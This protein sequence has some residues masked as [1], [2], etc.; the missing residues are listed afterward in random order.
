MS[1]YVKLH[2]VHQVPLLN[3]CSYKATAVWASIHLVIDR[4]GRME[5][6]GVSHQ[7]VLVRRLAIDTS[8]RQWFYAGLRELEQRGLVVLEG[9]TMILVGH[10]GADESNEVRSRRE[11]RPYLPRVDI[12]ER[13]GWSCV[14]CESPV[15]LRDHIDH[16]IPRSRGGSDDPSNLVASC[17]PCNLSKGARTPQEWK[18]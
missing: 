3:G 15:T 2:R 4:R 14:Y 11:G 18:S 16:V 7:D 17:A 6:A 5:L 1:D 10:A 13:D 12:F 8:E 9:D